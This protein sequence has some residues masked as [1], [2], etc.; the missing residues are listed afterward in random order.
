MI[1]GHWKSLFK[2]LE[3]LHP[4]GLKPEP[5]LTLPHIARKY[6]KVIQQL[7]GASVFSNSWPKEHEN[8]L[9]KFERSTCRFQCLPVEHSEAI[10]RAPCMLWLLLILWHHPTKKCSSI[11]L[12]ITSRKSH[13]LTKIAEDGAQK[14]SSVAVHPSIPL[15]CC[16]RLPVNYQL[17]TPFALAAIFLTPSVALNKEDYLMVRERFQKPDNCFVQSGSKGQHSH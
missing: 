11:A 4:S 10:F 5:D 6:V 12:Q 15:H 14:Q 2:N 8:N 3:K 7:N 1:F 13:C 9:N 17:G 16:T